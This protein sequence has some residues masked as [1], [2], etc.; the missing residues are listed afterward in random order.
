MQKGKGYS[1]YLCKGK[2]FKIRPGKVRDNPYLEIIECISCGLVF[3]SSFS[4]IEEGFYK[5]S[6]MH[7]K[8]MS[9]E[10]WI[11]ETEWD[12]K[13]RFDYCNQLIID[14]SIL[15]FG[16]G[17]GGFLLRARNV[18][19]KV[20]GVEPEA[21]LKNRFAREG[22]KVFSDIDD[23][24]ESFDVITLFQVLE[25][26]PDPSTLLTRLAEKLNRGGQIIVEVPNA[27]DA[28]LQLYQSV[29]FSNFTYWSC[30]LFL[31]SAN[32]LNK[33]GERVGFKI[34]YIRQIQRYPL[35]NHLYWLSKG[36]PG[37]HKEWAFLNSQ[38]LH[39]AYE[40]QLAQVGCCDTLLASFSRE[41][42]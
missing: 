14:K 37:G 34:N 4:H 25:H 28:L 23:I 24:S 8:D 33:L 36:K 21:R 9:I 40:K 12:D 30:H 17:T 32:T 42:L 11:K 3:L 35:S 15:D 26:I 7:E 38:P 2:D 39:D 31:F 27:D 19:K 41:K 13:R 6:G 22:L 16:C 20:V 18:A 1:C 5:S 10:T 29:P